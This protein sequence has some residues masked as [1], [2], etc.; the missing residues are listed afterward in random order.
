MGNFPQIQCKDC[1]SSEKITVPLMNSKDT[2]EVLR[3]IFL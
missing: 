1:N 3:G 2:V